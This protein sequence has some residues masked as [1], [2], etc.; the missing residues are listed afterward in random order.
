MP[1]SDTS[2]TSD[3]GQ[4][5]DVHKPKRSPIGP[6]CEVCGSTTMLKIFSTHPTLQGH[7]LRTYGCPGCK[8]EEVVT[9]PQPQ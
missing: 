4:L 1:M 8:R 5:S 9:S 2:D 7:E 3:A 6:E